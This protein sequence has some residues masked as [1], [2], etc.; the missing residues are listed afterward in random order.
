MIAS[1]HP[2]LAILALD[3]SV[4]ACH[5]GPSSVST[6]CTPIDPHHA[7][8]TLHCKMQHMEAGQLCKE[9]QSVPHEKSIERGARNFVPAVQLQPAT[10]SAENSTG[11]L[12]QSLQYLHIRLDINLRLTTAPQHRTPYKRKKRVE[13]HTKLWD[14][15]RTFCAL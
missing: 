6:S 5:A 1:T 10:Q 15:R 7:R 8:H 3:L 13:H 12:S 14:K 9:F 11:I 2:S 4:N